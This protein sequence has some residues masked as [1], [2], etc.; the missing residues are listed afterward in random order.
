MDSADWHRETIKAEIRKT[1]TTLS[2]LAERH[3]YEES[4]VRVALGRPWPAVEK[5][6]ADLLGR[7]P[8]A[9][10]PSRYDAEGRPRTAARSSAKLKRSP[11]RRHRQ[12]E[13]R[14]LT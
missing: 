14:A 13:T 6:V 9:I 4:A 5:I 11:R 8:K 3:G 12:N 10:W 2:A 1:G 7:H